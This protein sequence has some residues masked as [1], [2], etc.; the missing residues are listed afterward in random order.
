MR[1]S[2]IILALLLCIALAP[3]LP[4][5]G[6]LQD[7]GS[8]RGIVKDKD[9]APLP[10][11]SIE[12]K[13]PAMMGTQTAVTNEQGAFRLTLLRI[14]FYSL[15]ANLPGFQA[16][17]RD[18]LQVTLG[19]T[20]N[21][22]IDLQPAAI[23]EEVTVTAASPVVDVKSSTTEKLF[24][25]ELL[26]NVPIGRDLGTIVTLTP[27]VVSASSVKGGTA[28]NTLYHVDGLY[29]NDPDNAQLG[30]NVDFNIMEE[31][32]IITGGMP[33]EVG[34][35]SG[36]Y[37]N[38]V[39]R[40]GGNKLSGLFQGFVNR[41]PWS[42]MVVTEDQLRGLGLGLPAVAVYSFDLT[43]SLGGPIIKDKMWFFANG[44]YG[45]NENRSGFVPWTS[46]LGVSYTDFNREGYNFGGMGKLTFQ[47]TKN[48]RIMVNGNY[49]AA[50]ANTRANGLYMPFDCTYTDDPWAN[51]NAFGSATYILN[52]DTFIEARVG[53]LEVSAMLLLPDPSQSG[54]DLNLV[55]HNYDRYTILLVRNG[56][57][58]ERMDRPA[59]LPGLAPPDPLPGQ[60]PRRRPR[61]QGGLRA[62]LGGLQLVRLAGDA[63]RPV[64][65]QRQSV[66][67]AR[68]TMG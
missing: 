68:A 51:T 50:Y 27:G 66:L 63:P 40:S 16:Y 65:V 5:Q 64:L 31:V 4:A 8:I 35:A 34:I 39:T 47:P 56:R 58:D 21:L 19:G 36:G 60:P 53:Y 23:Q 41:E 26:Q 67:L 55:P 43:G 32:E 30:A 48:L 46:P 18:G 57:P 25:A 28:A 49:R 9:G 54:V 62:Q 11:V 44:R 7:T 13:S 10:G 42:T 24:R 20:I 33:A 12:V 1:T 22:N 38:A 2:K 14:G 61:I 17:K 52:S 37:V 45:A 29:A 6:T 59:D 3:L 15:T